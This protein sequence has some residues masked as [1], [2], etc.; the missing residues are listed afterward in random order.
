PYHNANYYLHPSGESGSVKN[1]IV[2]SNTASSSGAN[3]YGQYL[4]YCCTTPQPSGLGNITNEP[5][6][7]ADG[8]HLDPE[9]PCVGAGSV[10]YASGMDLDGQMWGN[11]PSIGCDEENSRPSLH[12]L[13]FNAGGIASATQE[14]EWVAYGTATGGTVSLSF[15]ANTGGSWT[16]LAF[17][18]PALS[19]V[20]L[21]DTTRTLFTTQALWRVVLEQDTNVWDVND[22]VFNIVEP[23]PSTSFYV[24]DVF[25]NGDVYCVAPGHDANDGTSPSSPKASL[26][27]II[28]TYDIEPGDTIWVDSGD[29]KLSHTITIG[30]ADAGAVGNPV[31]VRG[32]ANEVAGGPVFRFVSSTSEVTV[33]Q[34]I[35]NRGFETGS[36]GLVVPYE[37]GTN[38]W[39]SYSAPGA[40]GT[41]SGA[42]AQPGGYSMQL[43][44][45][46]GGGSYALI[47]QDVCIHN[48]NHVSGSVSFE[49]WFRGDLSRVG[50]GGE[51]AGAFLKM[52]FLDAS[53]QHIASPVENEWNNG[54]P[55]YGVN[56]S[57]Q[58]VRVS[59]NA[60]NFPQATAFVRF[61]IGLNTFGSQLPATGWWDSV[62]AVIELDGGTVTCPTG[63]LV[64]IQDASWLTIEN[65]RLLQGIE[66]IRIS[67]AEGIL[68][69]NCEI[70]E[71]TTGIK[72]S[73]SIV[74]IERTRIAGGTYGARC[75]SGRMDMDGCTFWGNKTWQ[76]WLEGGIGTVSNSILATVNP[77][78]SGVYIGNTATYYGDYNNHYVTANACVGIYLG[79]NVFSLAE[80]LA[81]VAPQDAHSLSVDPQFV[82]P[83]DFHLKSRTGSWNTSLQAWVVNDA[84]SPCIDTADPTAPYSMEPM[85]NGG[86]RNMGAYGN[87][88][89][90]SRS[91]DVDG[92]GL[93]DSFELY[94]IGSN[95]ATPD[96]DGDGM[97]DGDECR[98]GT[99]PA[100]ASSVFACD[101]ENLPNLATNGI[102][103]LTWPSSS[104]CVYNI[105]YSINLVSGFTPLAVNIPATYPVNTYLVD[106][107]AVQG[108]Y[109]RI[110]CNNP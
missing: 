76:V 105:E 6:F 90:A 100:D 72:S 15:S 33:L 32:S 19:Q 29:Y 82:A 92:D 97:N 94:R 3:W 55:L 24:N 49:G 77:G 18:V 78:G 67:G 28:D 22:Q 25:T 14:L 48:S 39:K 52:E 11:P 7:S 87:T 42:A 17:H 93:S 36:A 35:T 47:S 34:G 5:M 44:V 62:A 80:W 21:W 64:R 85:P 16:L 109:Y 20:Y 10:A 102:L 51:R 107:Q 99:S 53:L 54:R 2:S 96:S 46:E 30:A 71:N 65:L 31:V 60:T 110:T 88:P 104:G 89:Q 27:A 75:M 68:I 108:N 1:S 8:W 41:W 12:A 13:T 84:D 37:P 70:K 83:G 101:T 40:R 73:G 4:E 103:V 95:L 26:Q 66:G 63:G 56:T 57:G 59:I 38:G 50:A 58:W 79:T 98:T 69:R 81:L 43:T 45:D 61:A 91:T 74:R 86:H 106:V 9:S 23:H